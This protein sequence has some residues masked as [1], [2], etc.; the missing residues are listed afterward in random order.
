MN[1]EERAP[2]DHPSGALYIVGTPIG[3]LED[4][5]L[6]ALRILREADLI[7]AEDTRVTRKLLSRYEI[8]APLTSYHQHSGGGKTRS[9]AD[10]VEEGKRIALVTDA[11][12]PGVSDPGGELIEECIRRG[13]PVIPVPGPTAATAALAGSGLPTQR[14]AFDGFPPRQK[15]NRVVFFN[16]LREEARTILLYESPRRLLETLTDLR[17]V[18][19]ENRRIVVGR[20][21][22]KLHEEFIRGS[23]DEVIRR[24]EETPPRGECVILIAGADPDEA[25][26]VSLEDIQI[27]EGA[28]TRDLADRLIAEGMTRKEAYRAALRL[29]GDGGGERRPDPNT[30]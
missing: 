26:P 3:N 22:T 2:E 15:K 25:R 30:E 24:F 10:Q 21:L 11:G 7:A 6:R 8:H 23:I 20:E 28:S 5:T 16:R 27:P 1:E 19:G 29:K 14:F 9:L 4:I 18:V 12:M 13:L 17:N